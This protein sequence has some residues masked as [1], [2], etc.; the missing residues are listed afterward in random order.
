[1]AATR[2]LAV[3]YGH[4]A[5]NR[6]PDEALMDRG[7]MPSSPFRLLT[8]R[9]P[10]FALSAVLLV[11]AA[12]PATAQ[13]VVGTVPKPS[14]TVD[15]SVLDSLGPE[16]TLPELLLHRRPKSTAAAT[17][18]PRQA[19]NTIHLHAPKEKAKKKKE[20]A[21]AKPKENSEAA[22]A[23][24]APPVAP[25]TAKAEAAPR[26]S[27]A[28]TPLPEPM[29]AAP[30][31]ATPAEAPAP[32]KPAAP[33]APR[34]PTVA[35]PSPAPVA[36]PPSPETATAMNTP[37]KLPPAEPVKP[38]PA[39]AP[40]AVAAGGEPM[41]VLFTAD[42]ADLPDK[43][44]SELN[45][46]AQRLT[47]DAHLRLQLVAYA[48][49]TADQANQARRVS[50]QRALAVRSYLMEHG[51]ANTRMDVRALGNRNDGEEPPDRVDLVMLDH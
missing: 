1:V 33:A 9:V 45:A 10:P 26:E 48:S 35:P 46:V 36:P 23:Q 4:D 6:A 49:G 17:H 22:A 34:V 31:A 41:R 24:P 21:K 39:A 25:V 3:F 14:V 50:L 2:P 43:A 20:L 32:A 7:G 44:K 37:P 47:K 51:V 18:R 16:P 40:A 12:L 19:R 42:K 8:N 28:A 13:T 38:T 11:A 5:A 30:A 15:Q 27:V 29:P